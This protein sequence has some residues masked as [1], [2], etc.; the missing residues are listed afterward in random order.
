[1]FQCAVV[2]QPRA[3]QRRRPKVR[4]DEAALTEAI[5]RL[6]KQYGRYGYRRVRQLLVD[7]GWRVGVKRVYRIWRRE[8]LKVPK[9]QPKRGRLWLN[10][11]SCIRQRPQRSNHVWSYG[12]VQDQTEGKR[13]VRMLTVIDELTRTSLAIVVAR[14]LRSDDVLHCLTDLM[15]RH[16][17]PAHIRSDNGPEFVAKRVRS[18]LGRIGVKRLY[19]EPGSP[20]ENGYCERFNSTLR[21]ELLEGEQ[22]STLSEAQ[23]LIERWRRHYNAI[24]PH[25]SLGYR[26]PAPEVILPPASGLP[27]AALRPAH[28]LAD[29]GRTL[30]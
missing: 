29:R 3:T 12:F 26:P 27:Y 22:F 4:V 21:A 5:V 15:S 24:R 19:I 8:G 25:S 1:M 30:T 11:G 13:K 16:G 28:T 6:A 10:D 20:W 17:P 7:E 23:V 9:K 14:R 18:W 2:G